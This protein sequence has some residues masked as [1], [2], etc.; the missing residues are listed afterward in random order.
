MQRRRSQ[1]RRMLMLSHA[2]HRMSLECVQWKVRARCVRVC[3]V[4]RAASSA[5]C[6]L[7]SLHIDGLLCVRLGH[8]RLRCDRILNLSGHRQES[9]LDLTN[10]NKSDTRHESKRM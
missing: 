4:L 7:C 10:T 3:C 2:L 1:R 6:D 9:L 5:G 8:L